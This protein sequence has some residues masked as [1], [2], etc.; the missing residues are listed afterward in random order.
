MDD[1]L[2]HKIY[3]CEIHL[4]TALYKA[5]YIYCCFSFSSWYRKLACNFYCSHRHVTR[6][7]LILFLLEII[8][9]RIWLDQLLYVFKLGLTNQYLE[10]LAHFRL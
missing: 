4:R 5:F 1:N 10:P 3:I 9:A 7:Q 8:P 2:I 6:K